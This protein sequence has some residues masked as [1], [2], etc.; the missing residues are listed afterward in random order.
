MMRTVLADM[1]LEVEGAIALMMRLCRSFDLAGRE[2][3]RRRARG[4]SRRR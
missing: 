3:R 2:P 4:C 1:A